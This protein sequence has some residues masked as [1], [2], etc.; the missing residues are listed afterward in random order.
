MTTA[1]GPG[2]GIVYPHSALVRPI[3]RSFFDILASGLRLG[4]L[5]VARLALFDPLR[6]T[7]C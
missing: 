4:A 1:P 2:P 6:K 7:G 5:G 3:G